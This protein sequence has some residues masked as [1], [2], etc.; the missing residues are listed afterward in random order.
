MSES[1]LQALIALQTFSGA[2]EWNAKLFSVIGVSEGEAAKALPTGVD[3]TIVTTALAVRFLE[4][5]LAGEKDSWELLVDKARSWVEGE[6][7]VDVWSVA[8][9]ILGA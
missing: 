4:G 8:D 7:S 1:P 9:K 2:W 6:T 5:K 3:K